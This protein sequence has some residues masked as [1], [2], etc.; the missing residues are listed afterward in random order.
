M[1]FGSYYELREEV[2][3]MRIGPISRKIRYDNIKSISFK[4]NWSSSWAMSYDRVS[5]E[6]IHKT[7]LKSDVQV[8]PKEKVEFTDDL[9]RRCRN[10]L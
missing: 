6:L 4:K 1:L 2:L 8:G 3:F 10:I 7:F 9:R 5:I